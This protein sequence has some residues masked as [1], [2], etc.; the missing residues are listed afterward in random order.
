M[1]RHMEMNI[2]CAESSPVVI[3]FQAILLYFLIFWSLHPDDSYQTFC[4]RLAF[5]YF[6]LLKS[7]RQLD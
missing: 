4:L 3:M 7:Y 1:P 6:L 2:H 5:I